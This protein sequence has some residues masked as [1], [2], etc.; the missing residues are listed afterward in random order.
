MQ[1]I[2]HKLQDAV[3][4]LH[5]C[6]GQDAGCKAA[7]HALKYIFTKD[8]TEAVILLDA[9][10]AFN[11]LNRQITLLNCQAICSSMSPFLTN[12]IEMTLGC[13]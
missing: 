2:R 4:S 7:F 12:T 1:T 3:G 8:D 5:L 13:V 10:N 11:M 6:T 9:T